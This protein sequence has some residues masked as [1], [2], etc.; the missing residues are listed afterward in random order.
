MEVTIHD[1]QLAAYHVVVIFI[2][3]AIFFIGYSY[4]VQKPERDIK[5][6]AKEKYLRLPRAHRLKV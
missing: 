1:Y 6:K 2:C 5:R 3:I 4:G